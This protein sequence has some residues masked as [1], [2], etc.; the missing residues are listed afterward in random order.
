MDVHGAMV[1]QVQLTTD[2]AITGMAWSAEKFKMEETDEN[3]PN[4]S[5]HAGIF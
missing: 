5:A 2:A 1:S 4:S 3:D